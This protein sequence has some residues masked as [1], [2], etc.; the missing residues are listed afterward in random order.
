M[1][2][3]DIRRIVARLVCA[4]VVSG[5]GAGA[6][7]LW[8]AEPASWSVTP[9]AISLDEGGSQSQF[10]VIV[11]FIAIGCVVSL[12]WGALIARRAEAWGWLV[13]PATVGVTV[14]AA[15][16]AWRVGVDFGPSSLESQLPAEAGDSVTSP[17]TVD[18]VV[19]FLV[20]PI[21]GLVAVVT[22]IALAARRE[23][24][25]PE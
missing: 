11:T 15:V 9:E 14:V 25:S 18:S 2:R 6:V 20:W 4:A 12:V 22:V 1:S 3:A 8:W 13:V 10:A 23:K 24:T 17:L 21:A 7:W 16:V 19:P 5:V